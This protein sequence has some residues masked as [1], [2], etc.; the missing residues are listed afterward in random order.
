[1]PK[2]TTLLEVDHGGEDDWGPVGPLLHAGDHGAPQGVLL[3]PAV[4]LHL[5]P[6][7][8]E[9]QVR[10]SRDIGRVSGLLDTE[11]GTSQYRLV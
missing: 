9:R 5:L 4:C 6:I 8:G 10:L 2:Q 7:R 11:S 3:Q 1:M